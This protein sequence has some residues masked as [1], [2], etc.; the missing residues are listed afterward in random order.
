MDSLKK[1]IKDLL[2]TNFPGATFETEKS[3]PDKV[4]GFLIWSRFKGIEQIKRQSRLWKF[5]EKQ[6]NAGELLRVSTI[7]T[8]TPEEMPVPQKSR[9]RHA[10]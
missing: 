1:K 10:V 5:L 8:M 7:L 3:G 4:A 9:P 6:L 2:E